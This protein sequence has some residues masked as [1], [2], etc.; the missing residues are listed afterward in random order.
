[1]SLA[2]RIK[3]IGQ[4]WNL[5]SFC[6]PIYV[7]DGTNK[8]LIQKTNADKSPFWRLPVWIVARHHYFEDV[9]DYPIASQKELKKILSHEPPPGPFVGPVVTSLSRLNDQNV[10]VT[11]W[12]FDEKSLPAFPAT[13]ILLIPESALLPTDGRSRRFKHQKGTLHHYNGIEGIR[14]IILANSERSENHI[15]ETMGIHE[16][17]P[18]STSQHEPPRIEDALTSGLKN[19]SLHN[20][21]KF[22][23]N[24]NQERKP[25]PWTGIGLSSA[26]MI[27][28]YLLFT[29]IWLIG[30]NQ[31]LNSTLESK[32]EQHENALAKQKRLLHNE[33]KLQERVQLMTSDAPEWALWVIVVDLI[34]EGKMNLRALRLEQEAAT[35]IGT[36]PRAT[37]ILKLA[38]DHP[39][40]VNA[41][42]IQP[43]RRTQD[44]ED[45]ALKLTPQFPS[46]GKSDE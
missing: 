34:I 19:I 27:G 44:G 8:S 15:F 45:F 29:S 13:P 38:V 1:M 36:A 37:D 43:V 41:Q 7:C 18:I 35:I 23:F 11:R 26:G 5:L 6:N 22:W 12:I 31:I 17:I 20:L 2:D 9:Q 46:V 40:S 21:P 42:F 3:E 25:L 10:R 14:S 16:W 4:N 30:Y 32:L 28:L 39:Q 24:E 33:R